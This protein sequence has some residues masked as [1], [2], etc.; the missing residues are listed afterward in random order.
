MTAEYTASL[1][2]PSPTLKEGQ[3]YLSLIAHVPDP[4]ASRLLGWKREQDIAVGLSAHVTV[5]VGQL[6]EKVEAGWRS[7]KFAQALGDTGTVGLQVGGVS[8]FRPVTEVDYLSIDCGADALHQLHQVCVR[9]LGECATPF[10]YVPHITLGQNLCP[11]QVAE[12]KTVFDA[13]PA[14]ERSFAVDALHAYAYDGAEWELLGSIDLAL[15]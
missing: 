6:S 2:R 4:L 15:E 3:R 1:R 5:Y 8:T 13:L 11:G 9:E 12:A 14:A 10:P 7:V